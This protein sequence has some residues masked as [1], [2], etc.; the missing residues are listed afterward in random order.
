MLWDAQLI[1]KYNLAGPRYT[2]YPTAPQ[3]ST[4]VSKMELISKMLE[5]S[6]LPLSLYFHVPFCAHLCYY[7][8]CNKIVTKQYDKGAE[9]VELLGEEL[10]LRS[11]MIDQNRPVDQLH[12]GGGT[13]TFLSEANLRQLFDYIHSYFNLVTDG[14]QDYSI[15][16][17]PREVDRSK[18]A[19]L[20]ELGFNRVS[21]GIQ[22]FAEDV[23]K[24]IHRVQ[25]LELV[26]QVVADIRELGYRSM[27][28][29]LIYGLPKQTVAGFDDTLDKVIALSP[30]R[31][32]VF[33]YAHLPQRFTPQKR[34]LDE[35]L[36]T[37]DQKLALLKHTIEKLT[38]AGYVY[39][40]MDHFAKP[41]DTLTK[42]QQE[43]HL[44]RNF[45][46]YTTHADTDLLAFGVS[47]ISQLDG[48]YFQNHTDLALYQN[49]IENGQLAIMKGYISDRD[50]RIRH[51]VIMQLLC[52]NHLDSKAIDSTFSIKFTDYFAQE[53]DRLESLKE[54]GV[55]NVYYNDDDVE[56]EITE[57]GRLL[58]RCVC[59]VF[60][61]YLTASSTFSKVI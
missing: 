17:D 37:P 56:I 7:C 33:N 1:Q 55:I 51:S 18:L 43:G 47:A 9:Y 48:T 61:K 41:D 35:D 22:D 14:S 45:Q 4:E 50:D 38:A 31:I 32:S 30:D 46:G 60:D 36:P 10:R 34:I 23:Q 27:N 15:E 39:I 28:F 2:S 29:D 24:A 58:V 21:L 5:A 25:P 19:T 40:G 20:A 6:T 49:S 12:F 26:Q 3:F 52:N 57:A 54:D 59:M 13:P 42:A 44:Q 53:L 16:I 11:L 8:A